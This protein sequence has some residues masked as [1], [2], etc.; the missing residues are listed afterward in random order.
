MCSD[1]DARLS[2]RSLPIDSARI[3]LHCGSAHSGVGADVRPLVPGAEQAD[4]QEDGCPGTSSRRALSS[5]EV[6]AALSSRSP[7]SPWLPSSSGTSCSGRFWP[8]AR[9][10]PGCRTSPRRCRRAQRPTSTDSSRRSACSSSSCS[11]CSSC[12]P[13]TVWASRSA[14]RCSSSSV[15]RSRPASATWACGC[16]PGPT[17]G[18]PRRPTRRAAG[19]RPCAWRS[20]PVVWSA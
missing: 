20:A 7:W 11:Y 13:P 8:P 12:F 10:R 17:S 15:P 6:I 3:A 5:P 2:S 9:A 18:W 1:W 19:R 4:T 14:G 16:P